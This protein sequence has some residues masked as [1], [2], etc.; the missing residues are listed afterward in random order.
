MKL[1]IDTHVLLWI[2][3]GTLPESAEKYILDESNTLLFSSASI[4]EV[5][6]KRAL[7]RP[8]FSA[9]PR[10]LLDGLLENGYEQLFIT[11]RHALLLDTLPMI[12]KDPFDRILLAQ[13]IDEGIPLLTF[14]GLLTK[15][16]AHVIFIV[17]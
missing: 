13:S 9:D 15:Y 5:V 6:I 8:D 7:N 12:H 16:P 2:A 14:D 1:L 10:L 17:K 4:W 11:A 3:G